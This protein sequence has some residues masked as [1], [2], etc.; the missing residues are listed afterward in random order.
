M[1]KQFGN[2]PLSKMLAPPFQQT[3]L[4]QQFFHDPL[5]LQI[6][7]TRTT[8][9]L[10]GEETMYYLG[11]SLTQSYKIEDLQ[12]LCFVWISNSFVKYQKVEKQQQNW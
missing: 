4:F 3:P 10:G 5:F 11:L 9:I 1:M 2:P 12:P 8:L 6:S 7:K